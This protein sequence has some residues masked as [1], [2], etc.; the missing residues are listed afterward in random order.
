MDPEKRKSV[1]IVEDDSDIAQTLAN[2]LQRLGYD[3]AA[4]VTNGEEAIEM[5]EKVMPELIIMDIQLS[6]ELDGMQAGGRIES[7]FHIPIIYVTGYSGKAIALQSRGKVPIVKPFSPD[8]LQGAIHRAF[9][10]LST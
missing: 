10:G 6:G 2:G 9:F 5:A 7:F 1:L 3:V 8:D 4:V